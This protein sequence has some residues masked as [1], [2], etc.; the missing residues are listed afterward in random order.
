MSAD[1]DDP[2]AERTFEQLVAE[3]EGLTEQMASGELGIEAAA[4]LY[5]RA[6]VLHGLAEERLRRVQ[7]RVERLSAADEG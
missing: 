2:Y 6:Q 4:D 3:L 7:E 5:E 1:A